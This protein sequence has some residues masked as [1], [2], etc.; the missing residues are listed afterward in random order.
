M[1]LNYM[2]EHCE[3]AFIHMQLL[4]TPMLV[5]A[6]NLALRLTIFRSTRV[7]AFGCSVAKVISILRMNSF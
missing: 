6:L 5:I 2:E 7:I 4:N 3:T 1:T